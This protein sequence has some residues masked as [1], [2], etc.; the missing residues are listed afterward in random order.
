MQIVYTMLQTL[1]DHRLY[2]KFSKCKFWLKVVAFLGYVISSKG[3]MVDPQK[4][5]AVNKWPRPMTPTDILSFLGLVGYYRRFMESFTT[6][7][8]LLTKLTQKKSNLLWFNA[9]E[10]IYDKLKDKLTSAPILTLFKDSDGFMVYCD[11]SY[12][13]LD[14]VLIQHGRVVAYASIQ[15]NVHEK[16]YLTHDLELLVVIFAL[17]IWYIIYMVFMLISFSIIKS[18]NMCLPKRS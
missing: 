5:A 17:K 11:A 16:S 8:S 14:C 7:S 10:G 9:C 6:I 13:G 1:R 3:I 2:A 18:S 4:I 15:F 12:V